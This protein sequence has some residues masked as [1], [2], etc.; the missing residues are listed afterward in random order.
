MNNRHFVQRAARAIAAGTL[1]ALATTSLGAD[2][3]IVL[4]G[5]DEIHGQVMEQRSGKVIFQHPVLGRMV[6]ERS[7]IESIV[8]E[9]GQ[10]AEQTPEASEADGQAE[11]AGEGKPAETGSDT[12]VKESIA[13]PSPW[14]SRFEAG[15]NGSAGRTEKLDGRFVFATERRTD[16]TRFAFD[17]NYR[18]TTSNGDKTE[19]KFDTG[20]LNDWYF[21]DSPWLAFV[22]GRFELDE[23]TDYDQRYSIGGG[24]GYTFLKDDKTELVGRAG[25]GGNYERGGP[26]DGD[27][28]PEGV[29][30]LDLTHHF[31]DITSISAGAE[32]YPDLGEFGDYRAVLTAALQ[33]KL[34]A[35]S[36]ASLKFGVREEL[37]NYQNSSQEDLL[38][39]FA[40]F[41]VEF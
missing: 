4:V 27:F 1:L 12:A 35:T 2:D 14:K 11:A 34:S 10:P 33:T 13:E 28:T 18:T 16:A 24:V 31:N 29:L 8:L 30:K 22:Q 25:L 15:L 37:E 40:A 38:E 26:N 5:G 6:I 19:S 41:V 21:N 3:R 20:A 23:F 9:G 36:P 17:A 7:K 32:Y 39:F